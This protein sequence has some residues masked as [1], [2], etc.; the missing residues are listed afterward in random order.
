MADTSP[1]LIKIIGQGSLTGWFERLKTYGRISNYEFYSD[2]P[3]INEAQLD[4]I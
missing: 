2:S 4:V 1:K 3:S